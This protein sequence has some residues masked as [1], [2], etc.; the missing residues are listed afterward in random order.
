MPE[1]L[2]LEK[3]H[4][5]AQSLFPIF[6][7]ITGDGIRESAD[8]IAKYIPLR[9]HSIA[10]GREVYDWSIPPEWSVKHAKLNRKSDGKL[11]VDAGTNPLHLLNFSDPFQ[12]EVELEELLDHVFTSAA[13][14]TAIP[15]VTSYYQNRWG[16]CTTEEF[17][18]SLSPG[19]Y[20]VSIDVE[21][22]PG[23]LNYW[24][25]FLPASVPTSR[26]VL[27]S[28]YLC[29]P[30]LGNN[31]L[32]G[33]IA[34]VWLYNQLRARRRR[35]NYLVY[36]GPETIGS[37]AFL[38]QKNTLFWRSI[39]GGIVLTCLGGPASGLRFKHSRRSTQGEYT[40]F[41]EVAKLF[42]KYSPLEFATEGFDPTEG[43]DERQYCSPGF[44]LPVIQA[45]RT[46]YGKYPEYHSSDDNFEF[47]NFENVVASA[48]S[49]NDFLRFA[50]VLEKK[51]RVNV[52]HGEPFL[53]KRGLYPTMNI[54]GKIANP[55]A[56]LSKIRE[57]ISYADGKLSLRELVALLEIAPA[58][59]LEI[60]DT[61]VDARLLPEKWRAAER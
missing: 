2:T 60:I 23:N 54:G 48:E 9:R 56:N 52:L 35:F 51:P 30:N 5:L 46:P 6:R 34:L 29:H 27:L 1:T 38:K 10:T 24:T 47:M 36:V 44:N 39:I 17:K 14:P 40:L 3:L 49:L 43:S 11:L 15:Y 53:S 58:D 22:K 32:S 20:L 8:L 33:P 13:R 12:G 4:A 61:L 19:K 45:A 50:E 26:T 21:K 7:S 55:V 28:T 37:L 25:A 42:S 16:F 59:A 18:Q 31:E 41:D 57:F